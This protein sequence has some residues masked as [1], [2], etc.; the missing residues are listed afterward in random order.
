MEPLDFKKLARGD[1]VESVNGGRTYVV[2]GNYGNCVIAVDVM[3][4]T[5]PDEWRL[6]RKANYESSIDQLVACSSANKFCACDHKGKHE[7]ASDCNE[8][9][10]VSNPFASCCVPWEEVSE[11]SQNIRKLRV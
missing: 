9:Q 8:G 3:H 4:M 5:N 1:I 10:C 6:V 11:S 7:R 2:A